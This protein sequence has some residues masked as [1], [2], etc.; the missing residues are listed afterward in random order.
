MRRSLKNLRL[1]K[2]ARPPNLLSATAAAKNSVQSWW[3][4]DCTK[5]RPKERNGRTVVLVRHLLLL[6]VVVRVDRDTRRRWC[7]P[8]RRCRLRRL[9]SRAGIHRRRQRPPMGVV[10]HPTTGGMLTIRYTRPR[11]LPIPQWRRS[12]RRC[13]LETTPQEEDPP[14]TTTV[15]MITTT[16]MAGS[17]PKVITPWILG[18]A[19]VVATT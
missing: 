15:T 11:T 3:R 8:V 5:S 12:C 4:L 1:V 18:W 14:T 17:A 7:L 9:R 13:T 19:A 10:D 2:Q 16:K 6:V